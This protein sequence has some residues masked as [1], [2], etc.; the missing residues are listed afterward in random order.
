MV[1]APDPHLPQPPRHPSISYHQNDSLDEQ[2][3]SL[4]YNLKASAQGMF[5]QHSAMNNMSTS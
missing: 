1:Y 2:Q 3:R 5:G 4:S